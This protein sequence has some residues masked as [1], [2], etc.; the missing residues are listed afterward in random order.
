[1]PDTDSIRRGGSGVLPIGGLSDEDVRIGNHQRSSSEIS[2]QQ[3]KK[4]EEHH[5][6]KNMSP[7]ESARL[8]ADLKAETGYASYLAYLKAYEKN[9]PWLKDLKDDLHAISQYQFRPEYATCAIL[10]VFDGDD[11]RA[12]LRLSCCTSSSSLILAAL[13]Q[14][15]AAVT[16][17]VVFWEASKVAN[18]MLDALGLGL[19]IQP[20]YFQTVIARCGSRETLENVSSKFRKERK[21]AA[22]IVI[23]GQYVVTIVRHYLPENLVA[24][25]VIVITGHHMDLWDD[26]PDVDEVLPFKNPPPQNLPN[27]TNGILKWISDYA[28]ILEAGIPKGK[29]STRS[30]TGLLVQSLSSLLYL[31]MFETRAT[32]DFAREGYLNC[33]AERSS[34]LEF[35]T[36]LWHERGKTSREELYEVHSLLR[37]M[38]EQAEDGFDQL[39][40]FMHSQQIEPI[41]QVDLPG[42]IEADLKRT[43]LEPRRLEIEIRHYLQLQAGQLAVQESRKSI[44][45]SNIQIEEG[46]RG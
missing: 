8:W 20:R 22:D 2:V 21:S 4:S 39:R 25:P 34:L 27:V 15:P 31:H 13:R 18:Q 19:K 12:L 43:L 30:D 5:S 17:R 36:G 6:L 24:P 35:C 46:R 38:I 7:D 29:E 10:D 23:I 11:C 3:R 42:T 33:I 14:P 44:E 45:L 40:R 41:E 28:H 1:M 9:R 16:A 32:C 26:V 37:R